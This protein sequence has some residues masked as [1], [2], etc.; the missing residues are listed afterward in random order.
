MSTPKTLLAPLVPISPETRDAAIVCLHKLI[1]L[2]SGWQEAPRSPLGM[3]RSIAR[4]LAVDESAS[5]NAWIVRGDAEEH[6]AGEMLT[7]AWPLR[8]TASSR[9]FERP[10]I[11]MLRAQSRAGLRA[12]FQETAGRGVFLNTA[13]TA[14]FRWLKR[15]RPE[16]ALWLTDYPFCIPY[17]PA[18]ADEVQAIVSAALQAL[19]VEGEEA[20][21]YLALHDEV[22][23]SEATWT[24]SLSEAYTGMYLFNRTEKEMLHTVRL[25]GAGKTLEPVVRAARILLE[26]WRVGSEVWSCP[27]YTRLARE[28]EQ[29][30]LWNTLHPL[31]PRKISRLER[32]LGAPGGPVVAVTSYEQHVA[33]QIGAY[34]T[35][36]FVALGADMPD[37]TIR[38]E[39]IVLHAL[40]ALVSE[41]RF[42]V[43]CLV[44]AL[45][46]YGDKT[47][48]TLP[49][50]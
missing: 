49:R 48:A 3:G 42:P 15:S 19:Y 23:L 6:E 24:V 40:R 36:P 35:A 10:L 20:Y 33:A 41:G 17:D 37:G 29:V 46:R 5:R 14:P 2:R 26:D 25:L 45:N 21:Y 39:W 31:A 47:D 18:S 13:G 16:L 30:E 27:S 4:M 8:Y 12:A 44:E 9:R 1:G 43:E 7:A 22:L 50:G 28:G 34:V 38:A 11:Y 32:C